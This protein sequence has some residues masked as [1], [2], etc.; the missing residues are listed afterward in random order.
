MAKR[1]IPSISELRQIL[2][3]D[4]A[5]G[6]FRWS[7]G[8][9]FSNRW[10]QLAGGPNDRG[11]T[12]IR[13]LN[14]DWYAHRLAWAF[15]HDAW[16]EHEIDHVN[17][18]KADNRIANLREVTHQE[19]VRNLPRYRENKTGVPGLRWVERSKL[20]TVQIGNGG[21][22]RFLPAQRCFGK[23]V[24]LRKEAERVLGYHALN[25]T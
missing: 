24:M 12:K 9:R 3:Y 13:A 2:D 6:V 18:N 22:N 14:R 4:P 23:A 10:G 1:P 20:W 19:N 25:G 8:S 5:T 16:P 15:V 7:T 17:H 11:Y 21:K